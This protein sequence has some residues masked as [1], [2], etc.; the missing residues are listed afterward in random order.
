MDSLRQIYDWAERTIWN[1]LSKKLSSILLLFAIDLGFVAIFL[2]YQSELLATVASAKLA[3]EFSD[4]IAGALQSCLYAM[5]ILAI[6]ALC[7]MVGQVFY[8]RYLFVR[9]VRVITDIFNEIARGEGDFSHNLPLITYDEFRDLAESYNRFATKMRELI[10]EVRKM[11]VSIASEAVQVRMRVESTGHS[12]RQQGEATAAVFSSSAEA[13]RSIEDVSGSAQIIS[14][15]TT[16]NLENA[17]V[18]LNEMQEIVAKINVVGKKVEHFNATVDDL[19]HRS[20][21]V[22]RFATLIREIAD[23]TNLLA[24]NAAIEAARAGE[25]GRGF[26]VVADEVRK[27]A[28][29]VNVAAMEIAGNIGSML[30]LVTSTRSENAIINNDVQQTREVVGRSAAQFERMVADSERSGE[31]LHNIATALEELYATNSQIHEN[32]SSIH[33]LSGEVA[34]HMEDSERRAAG[35][36]KATEG[37]QEL[38]SRFKIGAGAFDLAVDKAHELRDRI[39]VQLEDMARSGIDVFDKRYLPVGKSTPQKF[40]VSW[41]DEYTRRC[42]ALLEDSLNSI[43]QCIYAVAVNTDGY[44]SAHN[45]KFSKPLTGDDAVDLA[46]NRTRRKFEA[47]DELRAARNEQSLLLRTYVRDTGEIL[48]D[49]VV[50][51]RLGGRLWGNVRIGCKA[52]DLIQ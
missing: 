36:T 14:D 52:E 40:S 7:W 2:H 33:R 17:K 47:P 38:V 51:I 43:P 4:R 5:A 41:G 45:L 30:S 49:L 42:Q 50:P 46:G 6:V 11:S 31:Q 35:L 32:V 1:S 20:E 34:D 39:Q 26:A 13:T 15:A 16:I 48:C 29:R 37:V 3:P 24:L 25:Q 22:H 8:F 23:Q 9:P 27:L 28:E 21:S 19:S 18:S 44:L 12:A 10:S